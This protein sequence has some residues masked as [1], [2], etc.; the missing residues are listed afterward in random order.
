[1]TNTPDLSYRLGLDVGTNSIGWAAVRLDKAHNPCGILDLGVRVYSDGRNPRDGSSL[2]AQRRVPRGQR[3]RRD[4]YLRRRADLLDALV[5]CGLM[6]PDEDAR[7]AL[8]QLDPYELRARA[9]DH[10]LTPFELGRALFHLNQRR[11]FKSNRKAGDDENAAKKIRA[12]IDALRKAIEETGVRT[13]GEFLARRTAKGG[14]VRARPGLG[15]YPDRSLYEAEFEVIRRA[16]APHHTLRMDQWDSLQDIIFFQRP[17]KRVDPGWCLLEAGEPRA[18]KALP[19]A[20]EFR[21][22]QEVNNLRVRVGLEPERPL[23]ERERQRALRRLRDGKD[24]AL[25]KG[26]D[27]EAVRPTRDL[28]LP[29][30]AVFNLGRGGRRS[31]EGDKTSVRLTT[32]KERGKA[33]QELFGARWLR[34]SLDERN[35]IVR[36]MLDTEDPEVVRQKALEEWELNEVQADALAHVT[37]PVGYSNL[38]DKAIRKILPRLE[39]GLVF[40]EAVVVAGYP[41]HSDFRSAESHDELPYYGVVLE[42][43]AVGADHTKDPQKDGEPERYGRFPNP[44]VHI[45]LNQIRRVVNRLIEV[46]GKPE[47]I[48]VELAR[49]LKANLEQKQRYRRQQEEGKERNERLDEMLELDAQTATPHVRRKFRLWE[50]Q[51]PIHARLCPFSGEPISFNMVVS[52]QTEIEHLLPFSRTLDDSPANKVLCTIQAN[53]DKGD[54]APFEAFGQNQ[55]G[56]DY[57]A[58]LARAAVLPGNKRWRFDQDAMEQF[59]RSRDFLDR[60]L[61]ETRYLS[62]TARSYLACLYDEKTEGRQRVFAIPGFITALLRRAWGLE[63]MLRVAETGEIVRKQRDDHRHHAIDALVVANTRRGLLQRFAHAASSRFEERADRLTAVAGDV[64]PWKGF[65]REELRPFLDRLVVSHKPDHGTRGQKGKTTGQLHNET[66]YGLIEF[67]DDGPSRVVVRK[68]LTAFKKRKDLAA[69]RDPGLRE[70][71]MGLWDQVQAQGGNAA[72]FAELAR[73]EGVSVGG[74]RQLVRRVRVL[75][76]QRVIPIRDRA[77]RPYKGYLP[78]SNEFADVWRMGD[79]AWRMVAVPRFYANQPSFDLNRFRPHPTAKRIMRLRINDM[80]ALGVGPERRIVRV[81]NIN[82]RTGR[83]PT[84]VLDD[85]NEAIAP[86]EEEF[87]ARQLRQHAFRRVGVD[88]I[89]RLLDPGPRTP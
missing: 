70:A 46:Y 66:A 12:D 3:R 71:L 4:R 88:E 20:Q 31:V 56:Y 53:R 73:T 75:D 58:I 34:L 6:P 30:G 61:N 21:M 35:E 11:G 38:S 87:S 60:Q 45:G 39:D 52:N 25:R 16:Q 48:V 55:L 23:D 18:A 47:E 74:R 19:V 17:L 57:Q 42:R 82:N 54:K 9:L 49:D 40:S 28:R 81:R 84:V 63:G 27:N 77:G 15:L 83:P 65:R 2:A 14:A 36:F 29:S 43:D 44:T 62:R 69:V 51:G 37:L 7:Q 78:D 79:G 32:K 41:H 1:M 50:E 72:E 67:V 10:P 68:P 26:K 59:E 76:D 89:G 5:A 64:R 8:T 80:G 13:L 33:E 86:R 22:L 24:I 85:H